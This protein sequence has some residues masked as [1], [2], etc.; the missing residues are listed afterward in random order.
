MKKILTVFTILFFLI[1]DGCSSESENREKLVSAFE[2]NFGFRPPKS[3]EK[4]KLKNLTIY[5]TQVHWMSFTYDF[6]V[7]NKIIAHD[8]PLSVAENHSS[9]FQDIIE[10]LRKNENNPQWLILPN[11]KTDRI[12]YKKDFL[13]HT[14]SEYFLWA[15]NEKAMTFLYVSFF[16]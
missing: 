14:F 12:Y 9:K 4:I 10:E 15:N 13:A 16:D 1:N 5:D 8:Q 3:V 11:D 6:K 7:L 2:E